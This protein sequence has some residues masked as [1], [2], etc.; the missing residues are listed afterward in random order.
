MNNL[1]KLKT[2]IRM[3]KS[4]AFTIILAIITSIMMAFYIYKI[5]RK[6]NKIAFDTK[7]LRNEKIIEEA[8]EIIKQTNSMETKTTP[9]TRIVEKIYYNDCGHLEQNEYK[10]SEKLINKN[11]SEFQI[12]YI[13][14]EIQ[15][16]TA[17]EV[18]V[19]KEV[20]D[21]CDEH[22]LVKDVEGQVIIFG[23]DKK[24]NEKEVIRETGIQTKYLSQ[25]DIENLK[26][27]IK[28][29]GSKELNTLIQDYE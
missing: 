10:I 8:E 11:E 9:N 17:N 2:V 21:F 13:G 5:D 1:V 4:I 23:L 15:K 19:Y 12:E 24:D 6:N 29:I 14:W 27:G 18:V 7:Y 3:K 22:Y 16:F 28:V 26:N 20:N 25:V